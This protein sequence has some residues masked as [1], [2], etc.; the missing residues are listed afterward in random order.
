[1]RLCLLDRDGVVV[2]NRSDN[3]KRPEQLTLIAGAA[4]AIARLNRAGVT[5]AICTNQP[6][7][8]QG[9]MTRAELDA[10]HAAL[11][12]RLQ[13]RGASVDR[14]F[15]CTSLFK[16]P[17]RKPAPGMLLEALAAYGASAAE[18]PFVGDQIDDMQAAFHAGCRR[19]LVRTGLGR[20]TLA[21]RLPDYVAP[22]AVF[23]DLAEA[24]PALLAGGRS[25]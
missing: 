6:E 20:K 11:E 18:T 14:I 17:M 23:D 19:V 13:E 25:G 21:D 7:V 22:F 10:V 16:C 3:I 5:V 8:G 4:E 12:A 2:V 24:V 1:M 15:S 9:A